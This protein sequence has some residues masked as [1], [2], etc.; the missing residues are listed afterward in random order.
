MGLSLPESSLKNRKSVL[1]KGCTLLCCFMS[2]AFQIFLDPVWLR[3][4]KLIEYVPAPRMIHRWHIPFLRLRWCI[5][6][7]QIFGF[8]FMLRYLFQSINVLVVDTAELSTVKRLNHHHLCSLAEVYLVA[9]F[10]H[11]FVEALFELNGMTTV[12][13]PLCQD[14]QNQIDFFCIRL[15][16]KD[17]FGTIKRK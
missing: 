14:G 11:Q 12:N 16:F 10:I 15:R 5:I 13:C 9:F 2:G 17:R 3:M 7:I 8:G 4:Y 1:T 6:S